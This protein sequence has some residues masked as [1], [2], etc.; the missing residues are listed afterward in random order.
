MGF[1]FIVAM[2][3][4]AMFLHYFFNLLCLVAVHWLIK[5]KPYEHWKD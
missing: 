2:H 1:D 4:V 5:D 3:T